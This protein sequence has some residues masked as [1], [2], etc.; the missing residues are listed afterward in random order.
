M[1]RVLI[2]ARKDGLCEVGSIEIVLLCVLL[3]VVGFWL[4]VSLR[5]SSMP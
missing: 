1:L 2:F 3:L 5:H 4:L